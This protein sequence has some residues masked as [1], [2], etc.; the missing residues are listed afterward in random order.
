MHIVFL[1]LKQLEIMNKI[2]KLT[3]SKGIMH[4]FKPYQLNNIPPSFD[5]H[6]HLHFTK[7]GVTYIKQTEHWSNFL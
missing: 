1:E 3:D 7:N 4:K 6:K 5:K 2:I